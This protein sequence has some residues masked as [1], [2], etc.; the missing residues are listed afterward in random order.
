[1]GD[2]ATVRQHARRCRKEFAEEYELL[3]GRKPDAPI[4]VQSR[5]PHGYRLDPEARFVDS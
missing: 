3:E 2:K 4:L 5:S 1:M